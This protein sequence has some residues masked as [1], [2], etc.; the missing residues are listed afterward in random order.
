MYTIDTLK[1][2][3]PEL[4]PAIIATPTKNNI[5]AF[6]SETSPCSN[7]H[8][9]N[10]K[11]KG[12]VFHSAEQMYHHEAAE[13]LHEDETAHKI[14]STKSAGEALRESYAIK[15]KLENS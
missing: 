10:I 2:L 5:T 4:D 7:F 8:A 12:N 1:S 15:E 11:A 13:F 3:P 14:L 6:Y 9:A